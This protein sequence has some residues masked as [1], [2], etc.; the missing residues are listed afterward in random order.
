MTKE[1]RKRRE[2]R[3]VRDELHPQLLKSNAG[4]LERGKQGAEVQAE[5]KGFRLSSHQ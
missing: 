5:D 3:R 1:G 4:G 2:N